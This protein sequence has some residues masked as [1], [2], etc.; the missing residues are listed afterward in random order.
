MKTAYIDGAGLPSCALTQPATD[1]ACGAQHVY[2]AF[3]LLHLDGRDTS[4]IPHLNVRPFFSQRSRAK[5][6][7]LTCPGAIASLST[8]RRTCR[9]V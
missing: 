7:W 1:G 8:P 2:Y 5:S 4:S 3:D 6:C 9:L